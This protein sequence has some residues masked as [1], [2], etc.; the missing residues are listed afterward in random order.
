M[1]IVAVVRLRHAPQAYWFD[2]NQVGAQEGDHVLVHTK[3]GKEMG[4]CIEGALE[5]AEEELKKP[6]QPVLRIATDEDFEQADHLQEKSQQ[7][8]GVFREL[9]E[10][11]ELDMQPVAVDFVFDESHGTFYFTADE[12]VDFRALVRDLASEFHMRVD[13]RQI[14]VRDEARMIGGLGHCG[15]ELCCTR[16]G[17]QFKQVSIRMAKVQ[18]LP[19]NPSKISGLCGRLMCCLRYEYEAYKDFKSRAPKKN[20]LIETPNGVAKVVEFDTPRETVR[21]RFEDGQ[22]MVLPVSALDTGDKVAKPGENLRPCHISEEKFDEIIEELNHDKTLAM[23]GEHV[24]SND[25]KLADRKAQ[26]GKVEYNPRRRRDQNGGSSQGKKGSGGKRGSRNGRQEHPARDQ[27]KRRRTVSVSADAPEEQKRQNGKA[28]GKGNA[29]NAS[30]KGG[31]HSEAKSKSRRRRRG[32]RGRGKGQQ[33]GGQQNKGDQSK[34]PQQ[35]KQQSK[36]RPGQHSST[37]SGDA[38]HPQGSGQR[39]RRRRSSSG[40]GGGKSGQSS[41]NNK[42]GA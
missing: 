1:P 27:R 36:P 35:G 34:K 7:A 23:M 26:A 2:P 38:A 11:H 21:V 5:V 6:L 12:R 25:P 28:Q 42:Q 14:G 30:G 37:V 31:E 10:K 17:G 13:M 18:D 3:R 9:V 22:S 33:N 41:S 4:L 8:M 20:G 29:R 39:R 32:G 24:F 15:E 19:L 40:N 16:F